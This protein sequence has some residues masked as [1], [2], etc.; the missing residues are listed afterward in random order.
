MGKCVLVN[1]VNP[2][3][4]PIH[5]ARPWM[6]GRR[7]EKEGGRK[8]RKEWKEGEEGRKERG[9]MYVFSCGCKTKHATVGLS[10]LFWLQDVII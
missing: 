5:I 6:G 2:I 1:I 4:Y 10:G 3:Q 7:K 9:S 8:E